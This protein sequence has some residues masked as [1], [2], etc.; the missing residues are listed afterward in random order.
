MPKIDALEPFLGYFKEKT[1]RGKEGNSFPCFP[2]Y[3]KSCFPVSLFPLENQKCCFPVSLFP[4]NRETGKRNKET[5]KQGNK[6]LEHCIRQLADHLDRVQKLKCRVNNGPTFLVVPINATQNYN[7]QKII[8][9]AALPRHVDP[10]V[11]ACG[12]ITT[13]VLKN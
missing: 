13:L 4:G 7:D 1:T 11:L 12:F 9:I 6:N 2:V 10:R 5:G 8:V 3:S